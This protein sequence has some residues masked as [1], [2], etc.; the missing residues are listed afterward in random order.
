[1]NTQEFVKT[2]NNIRLG[3]KGVW[4]QWKGEVNGKQVALKAYDTWVQ[5]LNVDDVAH[6]SSMDNNVKEFKAFL[7]TCVS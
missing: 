3:N 2:V 7:Q 4:Y 5:R 6:S 1:M